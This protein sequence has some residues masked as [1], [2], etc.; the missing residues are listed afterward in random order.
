MDTNIVIIRLPDNLPASMGPRP[1]RH[2]YRFI[3][4]QFWLD[5]FQLQ[6]GHALSGMDT[7]AGHILLQFLKVASM[8]PCP[9]R[10]GYSEK[11][12]AILAL[13]GLLQWGHALSGMD[14]RTQ[15]GL[16]RRAGAC[17]NGAMPFQAWIFLLLWS[18]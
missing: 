1:F 15:A 10:H 16:R 6:W 3:Y 13:L 4:E 17:F 18:V 14:M 12:T 11:W 7:I 9:F 5:W 8:G 2:G